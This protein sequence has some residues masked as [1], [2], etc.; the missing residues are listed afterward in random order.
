[1]K[2]TALIMFL[3]LSFV[4]FVNAQSRVEI[5]KAELPKAITDNI[6]KDFSG[7]TI[8]NAFKV[9][10]NNVISYDVTVSKGL[11]KDRLEYNANGVFVKK[12]PLEHATAQKSPAK[13]SATVKKNKG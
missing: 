7:Y 10:T 5:K 13:S 6:V 8:Q 1:M 11:D 9:T 12:V 2:K 3:A 4:A